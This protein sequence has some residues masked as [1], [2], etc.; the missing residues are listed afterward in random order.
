MIYSVFSP[1]LTIVAFNRFMSSK[2]SYGHISGAIVMKTGETVFLVQV[3]FVFPHNYC[4]VVVDTWFQMM[5]FLKCSLAYKSRSS[6]FWKMSFR[7]VHAA[8]WSLGL[9]CSCVSQSLTRWGWKSLRFLK[10]TQKAPNFYL[11]IRGFHSGSRN[12]DVSRGIWS[13]DLGDESDAARFSVFL[14]KW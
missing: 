7:N 3:M 9:K 14:N 4:P 2:K 12:Q 13:R 11:Q 10:L 5:N 6:V 8:F 1:V